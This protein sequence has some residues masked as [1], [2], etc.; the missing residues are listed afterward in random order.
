LIQINLNLQLALSFFKLWPGEAEMTPFSVDEVQATR[1]QQ[2]AMRVMLRNLLGKI[3][4]DRLCPGIRVGSFDQHVL[5]IFVA[6]EKCAA[7]IRLRYSDDF[8][9]AAEYALGR[10]IRTLKVAPEDL[11]PSVV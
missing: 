4:F 3:D 7:D 8:A 6:S 11:L 1:D 5:R 2:L 9:V 10:P